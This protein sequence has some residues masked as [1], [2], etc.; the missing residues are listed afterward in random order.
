MRKSILKNLIAITLAACSTFALPIG[1]FAETIQPAAAA[2]APMT[3]LSG[4][5]QSSFGVA[6]LKVEGKDNDGAAVISGIWN[7]G[8]GRIVYGRYTPRTVGGALVMEYYVPA[9]RHYGYAEFKLDVTGTVLNGKYYELGQTGDWTL[10]RVKGFRPTTL[11]KLTTV[12]DLGQNKT[13]SSLNNVVG[14]WDSTFGPVELV[15]AGYSLGVLVKGHFTRPDGKVG[16][17]VS[18][19][20]M[21]D[22]K[23]G[24]LKFQYVTPWNNGSGSGTFHPDP[25]LPNRQMLGSYEENGQKGEWTLSRPL[26][27]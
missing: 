22:Q 13:S 21:R 12:S 2:D 26:S 11:E 19:T 27:K 23:G 8:S 1:F 10:S 4:A 24:S 5:W 20:F 9:R 3:D 17:I 18:G 14:L 16:Q 15:S 25:H 7:N 6:N